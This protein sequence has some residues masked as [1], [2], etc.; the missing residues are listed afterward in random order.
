[1]SKPD[2]VKQYNDLL[3]VDQ[4]TQEERNYIFYFLSIL[5]K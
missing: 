1:M 5:F 2:T 4:W 3:S